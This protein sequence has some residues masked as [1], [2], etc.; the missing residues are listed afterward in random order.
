M[1]TC[2][3]REAW[4][5]TAG[6]ELACRTTRWHPR[7]SAGSPAWMSRLDA[8][9]TLAASILVVCNRMWL[10]AAYLYMS[11]WSRRVRDA[12]QSRSKQGQVDLTGGSHR[13]GVGF[14]ARPQLHPLSSPNFADLLPPLARV[15]MGD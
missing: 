8:V 3:W 1:H 15:P 11:A 6:I 10:G 9:E 13:R 4:S 5:S 7:L 12:K 2:C 14:C